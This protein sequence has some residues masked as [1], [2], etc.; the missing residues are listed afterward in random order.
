METTAKLQSVLEICERA[1][2]HW[3][4]S[5][6]NQ[7]IV[8]VKQYLSVIACFKATSDFGVRTLTRW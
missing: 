6:S 4:K 5:H 1:K 8:W 7:T 3:G 2:L